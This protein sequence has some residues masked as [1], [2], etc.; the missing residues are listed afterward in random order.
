MNES[1]RFKQ[2]QITM[3]ELN[4]TLFHE[5][6]QG[7]KE[8]YSLQIVTTFD[9]AIYASNGYSVQTTPTENGDVFGIHLY[10][11][12]GDESEVIHETEDFFFPLQ[13]IENWVLEVE[14]FDQDGNTIKD[15][16]GHTVQAEANSRPKPLPELTL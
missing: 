1:C 13:G 2:I 15:K 11:Q 4:C 5:P 16:N 8:K 6:S 14:Y 10:F 9:D 7:D 12:S 3:E